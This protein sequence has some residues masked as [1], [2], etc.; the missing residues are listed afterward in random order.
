MK[1]PKSIRTFV[2]HTKQYYTPFFGVKSVQHLA[3]AGF[4]LVGIITGLSVAVTHAGVAAWVVEDILN[5][6]ILEGEYDYMLNEDAPQESNNRF[7]LQMP[8]MLEGYLKSSIYMSDGNGDMTGPKL[9]TAL[10]MAI[11]PNFWS[12]K[13]FELSTPEEWEEAAE[14]ATELIEDRP[15]QSGLK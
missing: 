10:E 1:I 4:A 7:H 13:D 3:I 15:P 2:Q 8:M 5:R 14:D 12:S 9:D 6:D 11:Q